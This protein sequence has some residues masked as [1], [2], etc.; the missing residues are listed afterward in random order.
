[1]AVTDGVDFVFVPHLKN[2]QA[3]EETTGTAVCPYVQAPRP[4]AAP[5]WP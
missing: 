2:T 3:N 5:P 1:L 4:A